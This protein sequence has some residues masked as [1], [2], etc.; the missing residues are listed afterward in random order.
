MFILMASLIG[1]MR[2]EAYSN[3]RY[4]GER[5]I[6]RV[7]PSLAMPFHRDILIGRP[8][9]D[10]EM[11]IATGPGF[12]PTIVYDGKKIIAPSEGFSEISMEHGLVGLVHPNVPREGVA[13]AKGKA[14]TM[15]GMGEVPWYDYSDA[16]KVFYRQLSSRSPTTICRDGQEPEVLTRKGE[17]RSFN[18]KELINPL[19]LVMGWDFRDEEVR[20][21]AKGRYGIPAPVIKVWYTGDRSQKEAPNREM[22]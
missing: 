19:Y 1:D 14:I 15:F 18:Y 16:L 21:R 17:E 9:T 4:D 10:E 3:F 8:K 13:G 2:I 6:L 7:E 12:A 22:K 20:E 11:D 5:V